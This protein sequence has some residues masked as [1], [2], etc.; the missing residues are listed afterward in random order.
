MSKKIKIEDFTEDRHNFNRHTFD[1]MELLKKS[2]QN[3]GVIE[4]ITVS[5]DNVVLS[6]NARKET[7]SEVLP[8]AEPIVIEIDGKTPVILKRTD[9]E[10][11]TKK[12]HEAAL[13]ANTT[14]KK[15]ISLDIDLIQDIAVDNFDIDIIELGVEIIDLDYSEIDSL[16]ENS[17]RDQINETGQVQLTFIF[18]KEHKEA[19]DKY[20]KSYG[21]AMLQ[22]ELLKIIQN[23]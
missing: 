6:G 17:L 13:L 19:I 20:M 12:F 10:S 8:E 9:I 16:S 21:K 14:A 22:T 4:A 3:V 7:F 1:G 2:V 5:S 23:A 15:N 18:D 11:G